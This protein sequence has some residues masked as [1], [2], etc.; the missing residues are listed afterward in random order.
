LSLSLQQLQPFD[1]ADECFRSDIHIGGNGTKALLID[2]LARIGGL[3]NPP[4]MIVATGDLTNSGGTTSQ[5]DDYVAGIGTSTI[6]VF[7]VFGNNIY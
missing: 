6:P 3:T 7:S 2:A 1:L 5:Y 4:K